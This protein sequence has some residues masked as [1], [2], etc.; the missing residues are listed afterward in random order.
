MRPGP[1]RSAQCSPSIPEEAQPGEGAAGSVGD[2]TG[3]GL[4]NAPVS[5]PQGGSGCQVE[6]S[7][8][9][10]KSLVSS[11]LG[12]RVGHRGSVGVLV[13]EK[14]TGSHLLTQ[15]HNI[16]SLSNSSQTQLLNLLDICGVLR[17]QFS[18]EPELLKMRPGSI[19][20]HRELLPTPLSQKSSLTPSA[21]FADSARGR[22]G[23]LDK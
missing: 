4:D 3:Q 10:I 8:Q 15:L 6:S 16:S 20:T 18:E 9:R 23:E 2:H 7:C 1:H 11:T 22:P 5:M 12:L 17:L 19:G 14:P 13:G 21:A